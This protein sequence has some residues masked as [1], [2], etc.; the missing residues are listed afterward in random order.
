MEFELYFSDLSEDAQKRLLE[1]E[2]VSDPKELN[3][4]VFPITSIFIQAQA[5]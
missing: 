2:G 3:W 5:E 4:D 1:A